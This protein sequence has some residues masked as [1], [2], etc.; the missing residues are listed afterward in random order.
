MSGSLL[1]QARTESLCERVRDRLDAFLEGE[2]GPVESAR[3]REHLSRCR[4]CREEAA[5]AGVA[6]EAL[7]QW[8]PGPPPPSIRDDLRASIAAIGPPRRRLPVSPRL[9]AAGTVMAAVVCMAAL[10]TIPEP[11]MPMPHTPLRSVA[12]LDRSNGERALAMASGYPRPAPSIA[13]KAVRPIPTVH[14]R[15]AAAHDPARRAFGSPL[16]TPVRSA[17]AAY[18]T[19]TR[20][21]MGLS[22]PAEGPSAAESDRAPLRTPMALIPSS[23]SVAPDREAIHVERVRIGER[24]TEIRGEAL[25]DE[26]GRL[27]GLRIGVD[28]MTEIRGEARSHEGA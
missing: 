12:S 3:V 24:T 2:L 18:P 13:A 16:P 6:L 22:A 5:S 11:S 23:M 20:A 28:T 17:A 19:D 26:D 7:R 21:S 14:R 15:V 9:T 8:R 25:W 4:A 1:L 27:R 10:R